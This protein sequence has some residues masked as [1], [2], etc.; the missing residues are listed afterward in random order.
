VLAGRGEPA[1]TEQLARLDRAR[2]LRA[3]DLDRRGKRGRVAGGTRDRVGLGREVLRAL[4]ELLAQ[5]VQEVGARL[6]HRRPPLNRER[7]QAA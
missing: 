5:H 2:E 6:G 3:V 1:Q 7:P 4:Y